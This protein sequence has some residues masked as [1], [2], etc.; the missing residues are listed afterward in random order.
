MDFAKLR[1]IS[2]MTVSEFAAFLAC[3]PRTVENW[4]YNHR[5]PLPYVQGLIY[6]KLVKE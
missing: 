1:E 6:Y 3:A 5:V 2:G 4:E